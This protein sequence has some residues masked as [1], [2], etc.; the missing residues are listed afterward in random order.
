MNSFSRLRLFA[1]LLLFSFLLPLFSSCDKEES[2]PLSFMESS[3]PP[4]DISQ[5]GAYYYDATHAELPDYDE[6]L[7]VLANNEETT[8]LCY[9]NKGSH[10]VTLDEE[11]QIKEVSPTPIARTRGAC[12]D[13]DSL[14]SIAK[15]PNSDGVYRYHAYRDNEVLWEFPDLG[16][17]ELC[18]LLEM[19][20]TIY[21][22]FVAQ[23]DL[24]TP[25]TINEAICINDRSLPLPEETADGKRYTYR[26]IAERDGIVYALLCEVL[27][28]GPNSDAII[29]QYAIPIDASTQSIALPESYWEESLYTGRT[30]GTDDGFLA[31]LGESLYLITQ[32]DF[33]E[34]CNLKILGIDTDQVITLS[35]GENGNLYILQEGTLSVIQL[36]YGVQEYKEVVIGTIGSPNDFMSSVDDLIYEFNRQNGPHRA[37][38]KRY[39]S[40]ENL[41]L[42]ILSG[43]VDLILDWHA[44]TFI[45]YANQKLLTPL[46]A[47]I[48]EFFEDG[49][50]L[51]NL[52][53]AYK[54]DGSWYFLPRYTNAK[55][56]GLSK[57][58]LGER[59]GFSDIGDF[60]DFL[61]SLDSNVMKSNICSD[62]LKEVVSL[63]MENWVD[64]SENR[65]NF[66][67]DTF[68]RFLENCKRCSPTYEDA[69][70]YNS[71]NAFRFYHTGSTSLS[72]SESGD[73]EKNISPKVAFA[74]PTPNSSG[75]ALSSS[76]HLGMTINAPNPEGAEAFL[77]KAFPDFQWPL[78]QINYV[79]QAYNLRFQPIGIPIKANEAH[80]YFYINDVA[81]DAALIQPVRDAA[82]ANHQSADHIIRGDVIMEIVNEEAASYFAGNIIAEKAADYIQNRVSIYLAEQS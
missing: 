30:I 72:Y 58:I 76:S 80:D 78:Q 29:H 12:R 21:T 77:H 2:D 60:V 31:I 62:F 42:G 38:I 34:V 16:G 81:S 1:F 66:S 67:N 3:S 5:D 24:F 63:G 32:D 49:V 22:Y 61:D 33:S 74:L 7:S 51:E 41:N 27:P 11:L 55:G 28:T 82:F 48:P 17:F 39:R 45:N 53:E 46:E 18:Q 71:D 14:I 23:A 20:G 50:L 26:G 54:L 68:V 47:V 40:I 6:V 52:K 59:T 43:E 73:T 44:D 75:L 9:N 35:K 70:L 36:K 13:G 10:F 57:S 8:L 15:T 19:D 56:L 65:A 69:Q 4:T 37:R 64:F 25:Q 79:R